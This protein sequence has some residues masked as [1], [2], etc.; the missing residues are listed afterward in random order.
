M[1]WGVGVGWE[2]RAPPAH[3]VLL[4]AATSASLTR[5]WL[6]PPPASVREGAFAAGLLATAAGDAVR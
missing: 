1:R 5:G 4:P 6:P 2:S 3:L